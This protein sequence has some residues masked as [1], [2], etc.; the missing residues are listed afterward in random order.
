MPP[1][2]F[3]TSW[4]FVLG[5][6]SAFALIGAISVAV[7]VAITVTV[8][9]ELALRE[10]MAAE[11]GVQ[12]IQ[13]IRVVSSQINV[14]PEVEGRSGGKN[15]EGSRYVDVVLKFVEKRV[16]FAHRCVFPHSFNTQE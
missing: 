11:K 7:I 8:P 3:S 2:N 9:S 14:L 6:F 16:K 15:Y 4:I 10:S 1:I 5:C 13:A 12:G